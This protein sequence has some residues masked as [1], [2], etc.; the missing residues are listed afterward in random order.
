MWRLG[1][2][3]EDR[4][5]H[6]E[7]RVTFVGCIWATVKAIHIKNRQ[8]NSAYITSQTK[9]VY[10]SM[11]AKT[12]IFIQVCRELWDFADD[13]ERYY[14]KVCHF[15]LP[16]LIEKWRSLGTTHVVTVVLIS[17]VFYEPSELSYAAGPLRK[18][19]EG[20]WYKDFYK[21]IVDL[22]VVQDWK[23]SLVYLKESF[24][25]FQRDILLTHHFHQ[26]T[27]K[28]PFVQSHGT[29]TSTLEPLPVV[30]DEPVQLVGQISYAHDGPVLEAVNLGLNPTETHYVDRSLCL[31]GCSTILITP[32]T[33]HFRV[34][35]RLLRLTT[36]RMVDQGFG[37]DLV[38]LAKAPLFRTPIFSFRASEPDS[39]AND[40]GR[41]LKELDPLWTGDEDERENPLPNKKNPEPSG[42]S[43]EKKIHWWEPFW[44]CVS[45]WD[46]QNN[47]PFRED[48]FISRAR[49]Y[50]IQ[51]LGLLEHDISSTL[52][53]PQLEEEEE[54]VV[55][56]MVVKGMSHR[57]ALKVVRDQFDNNTFSLRN[58]DGSFKPLVSTPKTTTHQTSGSTHQQHS[59]LHPPTSPIRTSSHRRPGLPSKASSANRP[60]LSTASSTNTV[61]SASLVT[62]RLKSP[63]T[64]AEESPRRPASPTT[65]SQRSTSPSGMSMRSSTSTTSTSTSRRRASKAGPLTSK[66]GVGQWLFNSFRSTPSQPE[67][68]QVSI[69]RVDVGRSVVAPPTGKSSPNPIVPSTKSAPKPIPTKAV[70]VNRRS[71][72][73]RAT[74][75]EDVTEPRHHSYTSPVSSPPRE[76]INA[77][78][79]R[80]GGNSMGQTSISPTNP[81]KPT[82]AH[83]Y[84]RSPLARRWQ[85]MFPQPTLQHQI[86]WKSMCTPACL[87]LTT[88]YFPSKS[89]LDNAYQVYSYDVLVT[90]DM[91]ASFLLRK[92]PGM[93]DEDWPLLVM[94]QMAA[95][96]L[97]Q[98]F[99]FIVAPMDSVTTSLTSN[100][101]K[102]QNPSENTSRI[103]SRFSRNSFPNGVSQ[104][105]RTIGDHAYLSMSNQI[106]KISFDRVEQV[107]QVTRY[108]RRTTHSVEPFK[109]EC[110]VWPRLGDGY[111]EVSTS[112]GYP[113]LETYGW[114]RMDLLIAGYEHDLADSL[115][116]W[117]TRF[118]VIPTEHPPTFNVLHGEQLSDEEV[119]LLGTD[120][121]AELFHKARWYKPGERPEDIP[122]PRFLPTWLDPSACVL[123]ENLMA[124]VDEIHALGPLKKKQHSTKVVEGF[125][126]SNLI[127]AMK[128]EGGVHIKDRQWHNRL[129][130]DSF[131][132]FEF[133][134]WLVRE[135][136]D[137][138][139][140]ESAVAWGVQLMELELIE[141]C[142]GNH[143]FLDGNYFYRIKGDHPTAKQSK[144]SKWFKGTPTTPFQWQGQD[145]GSANHS[146]EPVASLSTP[147]STPMK[148]ANSPKKQRRR[149]VLSQAMIIDVDR[150]RK[151]TQ[152][153]T[154]I[155]HH[156]II[157]NPATAFHFELNWIGT[158]ARC[159]DDLVQSW[160][161]SIDRYGLKLVEAYVD[162]IA[163]ISEKNVFQSTFPI[164]LALPP[165]VLP[166]LQKRLP[167][168]TNA[169]CYFEHA[170]LRHH[171]YIM[172]IEA[173]SRYPDS[174]DVCYSYRRSSFK[175][176]Q[177]VHKSGLAFVQV[178][179]GVEGFRWLTNRLAG[180]SNSYNSYA[181]YI[182]PAGGY[183]PSGKASA[184][185]SV[186][187]SVGLNGP[188]ERV[189]TSI[190]IQ[191][192]LGDLQDICSSAEKLQT[193]YNSLIKE[194]PEARD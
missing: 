190:L 152:A 182:G 135:Y 81:S 144:S 98:G 163:S 138:P 104:Y 90:P 95:L 20:R 157:Q 35:K 85:H 149:L 50:E 22:E 194:L 122:P 114:N 67:A 73:S 38:C 169:D 77:I 21:V 13:G 193:F 94:R 142:R 54:A 4:C 41:G 158:T 119:R 44:V 26:N 8:V 88:E 170:I 155:L 188:R 65:P 10:R 140:R 111:R 187:P 100:D 53:I 34:S 154:V 55:S 86:K 147:A 49:M 14:E 176:S 133:V 80:R 123:D 7:Q 99:Q 143:G 112:F 15:F 161:S 116:Y 174:V 76:D 109:Y 5:I 40:G 25:S 92:M 19:D 52:A 102:I 183:V 1:M 156:D 78:G 192:Q 124:Q 39:K 18:D 68:S 83:H 61:I 12:T 59:T 16:S 27:R 159:I 160:S 136:K 171:G 189:A 84:A 139:T 164:R 87:P 71:A 177:F 184:N 120:R 146:N 31:T 107:I 172:D 97:G 137:V 141:H 127:K 106:H 42:T 129:Y 101:Q 28:A 64:V 162:P 48:R 180:T 128:E 60:S 125:P 179:G 145:E 75:T 2:S 74:A 70:S 113:S 51:M 45:F 126:L 89:E 30:E 191:R 105:L 93:S 153:E 47:M 3:L 121:L 91:H 117:R 24:W 9:W 23:P 118:I 57:D 63:M 110:L 166:D 96:R 29:R 17:R 178:I 165:P 58:Q 108:V 185:S 115:R 175:Y 132:G 167:E 150:A 66:L 181:A 151:S 72:S 11:S 6:V 33:G 148:T 43:K 186:A 36:S 79:I 46:Q 103:G 82:S 56:E 134:S 32:G 37:L 131:L 173:G 69:T 62:S 130:P 168:G